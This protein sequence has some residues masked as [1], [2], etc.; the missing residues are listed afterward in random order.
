MGTACEIKSGEE[1][2]LYL[3][4][5][6]SEIW[7]SFETWEEEL[8]RLSLQ[9]TT[10]E[11][12]LINTRKID[13]PTWW[14]VLTKPKLRMLRCICGKHGSPA[15]A[16]PD[17]MSL[18]PRV[19]PESYTAP[20]PPPKED[21]DVGR[22]DPD[23]DDLSCDELGHR[24]SDEEAHPGD[25]GNIKGYPAT[26]DACAVPCGRLYQVVLPIRIW[27]SD[28]LQGRRMNQRRGGELAFLEGFVAQRNA[29]THSTDTL[30][31]PKL[32][33][34]TACLLRVSPQ[35]AA[36]VAREQ[37]K[38]FK[39]LDSAKVSHDHNTVF[40]KP[41]LASESQNWTERLETNLQRLR[42]KFP[43][44]RYSHTV[45]MEAAFF[46]LTAGVLNIP[47]TGKVNVKQARALLHIA[48]WLQATMSSEWYDNGYQG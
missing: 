29:H 36:S 19:D 2:E 14:A 11:S 7:Q 26:H 31:L 21:T 3:T 46:L 12:D 33:K 34:P 6:H 42:V 38:Y 17:D 41:H 28:P 18:L 8:E 32:A 1:R 4:R 47:A 45:V 10:G 44:H 27:A 25:T 16:P 13:S 23:V 24:S 30:E 37:R 48:V 35:V 43:R 39:A 22:D 9:A 40:T 5:V 20:M 15:A